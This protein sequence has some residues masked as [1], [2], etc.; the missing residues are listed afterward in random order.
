MSYAN[1]TPS[2]P[3]YPLIIRKQ[4]LYIPTRP[5]L[6]TVCILG[7]SSLFLFVL[8]NKIYLVLLANMNSGW[9]GWVPPLAGVRMFET[10]SIKRWLTYR[11]VLVDEYLY[12]ILYVYYAYR[13][14]L[15]CLAAEVAD[16]N[17]GRLVVLR[18]AVSCWTIFAISTIIPEIVS[19]LEKSI[20][21]LAS[22]IVQWLA[23]QVRFKWKIIFI[24]Q[25]WIFAYP[26]RWFLIRVC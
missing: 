12:H 19:E 1:A 3:C 21:W 9:F 14:L 10:R 7:L 24:C 11:F 20:I 15:D 6:D 25:N 23:Y 26:S 22:S 18:S 2:P 16:S 8:T 5:F 4:T 13:S 17:P